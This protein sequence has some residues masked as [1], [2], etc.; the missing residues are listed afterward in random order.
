VVSI[1]YVLVTG[2]HV[3][4]DVYEKVS[5]MTGYL[6]QIKEYDGLIKLLQDLRNDLDFGIEDAWKNAKPSYKGCEPLKTSRHSVK[7]D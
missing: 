1:F 5:E 2:K 4:I 6:D 3:K 7:C